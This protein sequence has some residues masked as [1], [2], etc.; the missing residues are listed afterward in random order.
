MRRPRLKVLQAGHILPMKH[1]RIRIVSVLKTPGLVAEVFPD[2][3]NLIGLARIF[4]N[5]PLNA[6]GLGHL[7][8]VQGPGHVKW[9]DAMGHLMH[10]FLGRLRQRGSTARQDKNGR[11]EFH[12]L[13]R[14]LLDCQRLS[15][16]L[17]AGKRHD[18]KFWSVWSTLL[19][20]NLILS[21]NLSNLDR[22]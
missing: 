12:A 19:C 15:V 4:R 5:H 21:I 3:Q 6:P 16:W 11:A 14:P 18:D 7:E 13:S 20:D 9:H 10:M 17:L 8:D 22:I 1:G 2:K